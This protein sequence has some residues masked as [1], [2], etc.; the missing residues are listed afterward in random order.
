MSSG[1]PGKAQERAGEIGLRVDHVLP[2][3]VGVVAHRE[4]PPPV[5]TVLAKPF[6]AHLAEDRRLLYP[7]VVREGADKAVA[8]APANLQ[9]K[10]PVAGPHGLE[11]LDE[12]DAKEVGAGLQRAHLGDEDRGVGPNDALDRR[13]GG[14][15]EAVPT[16][17]GE[18]EEVHGVDRRIRGGGAP[19][20]TVRAHIGS[21]RR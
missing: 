6:L 12:R 10:G 3:R 16:T 20:L 8:T 15:L 4:P 2:E 11:R 9:D 13:A 14:G 7:E 21:E 17:G 5:M 19:R 1:R 18:L